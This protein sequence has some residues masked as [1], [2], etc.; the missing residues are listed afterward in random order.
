MVEDSEG[1]D[2]WET[3]ASIKFSVQDTRKEDVLFAFPTDVKRPIR[4][5]D[6]AEETGMLLANVSRELRK[7]REM[8]LVRALDPEKHNYKPYVITERGLEIREMIESRE[9]EDK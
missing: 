6:L 4:P 1:D 2:D 7:L 5:T 9:D 3:L 8:G